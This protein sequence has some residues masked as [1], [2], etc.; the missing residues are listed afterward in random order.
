MSLLSLLD[1]ANECS[2]K[3][4]LLGVR[5][6]TLLPMMLPTVSTLALAA[7]EAAF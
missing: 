1:P 4:A 7:R 2:T 5:L 6:L 3:E